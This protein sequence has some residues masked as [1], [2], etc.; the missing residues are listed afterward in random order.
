LLSV[1]NGLNKA[2]AAWQLFDASLTLI[3]GGKTASDRSSA[4]IGLTT[5]VASAGGTLLGASGFFSLYNNLYIGPMVG[6]ILGQIDQLKNLISTTRNRAAIEVGQLDMVNWDLEPG[7][8]AMYD[9]MHV[10]MRASSATD[11]GI[12]PVD[13]NKYFSKH[14]DAFEA[15]MPKQKDGFSSSYARLNDK[16]YWIFT[17][18]DDIWGMLYGSLRVP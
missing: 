8:R 6:H 2:L 14:R 12:I 1:A 17:F 7:G 15:G 5:T 9:F 4:G 11:I 10:V 3:S 18:R 16:R 13:V